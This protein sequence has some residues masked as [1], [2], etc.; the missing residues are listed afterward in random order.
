METTTQESSLVSVSPKTVMKQKS[1]SKLFSLVQHM[2][3][4][5][6]LIIGGDRKAETGKYR[7]DEFC[8]HN[9]SNRK[10]EYLTVFS[11]EQPCMLKHCIPRSPGPLAN[12][13]PTWPINSI[14]TGRLY[15]YEQ[16]AD[17]P[18]D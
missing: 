1:P 6:V 17:K 7:N 15:I 4:H 16:E 18:A 10:G 13:L 11:R 5:S 3:K 9:S 14:S 2:P 8:L 12:T